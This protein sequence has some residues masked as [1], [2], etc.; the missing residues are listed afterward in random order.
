MFNSLQ[1]LRTTKALRNLKGHPVAKGT[2][3]VVIHV[4]DGKALVRTANKLRIEA[5]VSA[6]EKTFRGRPTKAAQA[7][8]KAKPSKAKPSKAEKPAVK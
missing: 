8:A 2:R 1:V 6:F 4:E 3:V 7:A 5:P